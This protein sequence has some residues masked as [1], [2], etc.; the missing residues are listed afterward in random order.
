MENN[1]FFGTEIP[2]PDV[3]RIKRSLVESW[4]QPLINTLGMSLIN[5][6]AWDDGNTSAEDFSGPSAASEEAAWAEN[7]W[8]ASSEGAPWAEA[9]QAGEARRRVQLDSEADWI[10]AIEKN[11]G[12]QNLYNNIIKV[13]L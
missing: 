7:P 8:A 10:S 9:R 4:G 5:S 3:R 6:L 12:L 2:E 1:N 13:T 11:L